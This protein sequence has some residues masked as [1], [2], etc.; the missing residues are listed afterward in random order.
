MNKKNL[1]IVIIV[2]VLAGILG[3]SL[4]SDSKYTGSTGQTNTASVISSAKT[5]DYSN[6]GLSDFPKEVLGKTDTT[7]LDLSG[8]S[9]T[10]ALPSQIQDLTNLVELNVSNNNMTGIPAEIGKLTKLKV[11][12]FANNQITGLPN[13][14]GNLKQLEVFDLRGNPNV[15]QQDLSGIRAKLTNTQIKL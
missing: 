15:S 4:R 9:L 3:Y 13:E 7:V 5:A 10:G 11:L 14:L 6:K 12:N 2:A 1:I 8:N